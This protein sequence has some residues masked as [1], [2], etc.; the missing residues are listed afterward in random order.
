MEE[1]VAVLIILR[2]TI[3]SA[4]VRGLGVLGAR[5][6]RAVLRLPVTVVLLVYKKKVNKSDEMTSM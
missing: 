2:V 3:A 6:A 5:G 1:A 4:C